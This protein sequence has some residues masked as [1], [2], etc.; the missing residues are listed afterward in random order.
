MEL[1]NKSAN[2]AFRFISADRHS[3]SR[4]I[5]IELGLDWLFAFCNPTKGI[6]KNSLVAGE[7]GSR[8]LLRIE[9]SLV[10]YPPISVTGDGL[11]GKTCLRH[12]CVNDNKR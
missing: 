1:K 5:V 11:L 8:R 6:T 2:K 7:L 10:L 12:Q 4:R 3:K 9:Q